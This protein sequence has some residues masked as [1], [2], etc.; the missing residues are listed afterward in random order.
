MRNQYKVLSEAYD[1]ILTDAR[2]LNDQQAIELFKVKYLP[3]L[4]DCEDFKEFIAISTKFW[5]E[6]G[7]TI[8]GIPK[9]LKINIM[10][11]IMN[12]DVNLFSVQNLL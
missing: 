6:V 5:K 2:K 4:I 9:G 10:D 1:T 7:F 8:K 11:I 12:V 3:V